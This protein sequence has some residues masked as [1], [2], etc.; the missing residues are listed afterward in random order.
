MK[1]SELRELVRE[2]IAEEEGNEPEIIQV[3]RRIVKNH[4]FE[5]V[6]DPVTGKRHALDGFSASAIVGVYDKLSDKNKAHM[7]KQ[8]LPKMV[9]LV[10]KLIK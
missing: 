2:V 5:K 3:A 8:P 1:T 7:V 10:F 9:S 6:K 4:Q